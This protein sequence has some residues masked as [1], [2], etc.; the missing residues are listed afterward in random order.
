[1]GWLH[2]LLHGDDDQESESL[3][4]PLDPEAAFATRLVVS[5]TPACSRGIKP[6]CTAVG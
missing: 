5:T 6:S 2:K 3:P 1:M 4:A